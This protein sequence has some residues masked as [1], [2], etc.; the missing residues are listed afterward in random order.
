VHRFS[1]L[2]LV[3]VAVTLSAP[4][5]SP[6]AAQQPEVLVV[7][8]EGTITTMSVELVN[9]ALAYAEARNQP[10]VLTLDTPGGNLDATQKIIAAIERAE[11]PIIGY[12]YPPGAT[13]WS[14]GTYILLSTHIAAMAPHTI[15]GSAQPVAFSPFGGSQPIN[16]T[17]VLNALE[18]YMAERA[19]AHG[20]NETAARLFVTENLNLGAEEAME[21][22]VVEVVAPALEDLLA[23]IDGFS[24]ET[25]KGE[26]VLRSRGAE[27]V[28]WTPSP[29]LLVF[30]ILSEPM[31]AFIFFT[32]GM[33]ALIFGLTSP[34]A[35]GE[36]I[37][38]VLLVLGL[39]G[40]GITG[41]N[42]GALILMVLGAAL[43][44]A[45]LFT[46]GFGIVGGS[47]FACMLLGAVLLFPSQWSVSPEWLNLLYAALISAPLAIGVFFIFAA[48]KVLK[49]RRMKPAMGIIVGE[50]GEALEEVTPEK[51]GFIRY[52]GEYWKAKSAVPIKPGEKVEIIGKEGPLLVVKP[53][54]TREG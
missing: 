24:V 52:K 21:M 54:K 15:I 49:A 39:I 34:G 26:Y 14:A 16:D 8:L 29:G 43:L 9:E 25:V 7:R 51:V 45:E 36:V 28:R 38:A 10:V 27:L 4:L 18:A 41:I 33:Y 37:G 53:K 50:E 48:Y 42:V 46:P 35:G 11:V 20:R 30:K 23:E 32:V 22:G 6:A 40:L 13:A 2:L 19:R 1:F 31:L 5:L 12:V 3:L 47:G 44:L 17:K